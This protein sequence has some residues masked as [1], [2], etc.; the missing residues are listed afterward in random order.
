MGAVPLLWKTHRR[1]RQVSR[2]RSGDHRRLV[3]ASELLQL[4]DL[5]RDGC[6][7]LDDLELM[8]AQVTARGLVL[9]EVEADRG[10]RHA[11]PGETEDDPRAILE[12]DPDALVLRHAAVNRVL[13]LED[14]VALDLHALHGSPADRHLRHL[15]HHF[16]RLGL[17]DTLVVVA[18]VVI[19][20][21]LLP[22]LLGDILHRDQLASGLALRSKDLQPSKDR[23]HPI[24]LP[25]MISPGAEGLLTTNEG[26]VNLG[27][28]KIRRVA[29]VHEIAKELP[30]RRSLEALDAQFLSHEVHGT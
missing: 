20:P 22:M 16:L 26:G 23:P 6:Q 25:D 13:V 28:W 29:A 1:V 24:L 4:G 5:Q 3:A 2:Y 9:L 30:A 8:L 7:R 12:D 11:R 15:L 27:V 17:V 21:E 19:P 18:R 10:A 14:V